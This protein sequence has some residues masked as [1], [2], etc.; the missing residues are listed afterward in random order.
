[1]FKA[2]ILQVQ[3]LLQAPDLRQHGSMAA[4]PHRHPVQHTAF[5]L[6]L[7]FT[8]LHTQVIRGNSIITIEAL[9]P[10]Y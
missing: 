8:C 10:I 2:P 4:P 5:V 7:F 1:M 3:H 9:E 6:P